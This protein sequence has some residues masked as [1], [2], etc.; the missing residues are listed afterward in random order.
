[1][2]NIYSKE[3]GGLSLELS[4]LSILSFSDLTK[5]VLSN[6]VRLKKHE[7]KQPS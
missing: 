1:M 7:I 4:F 3:R 6:K 2:I 5:P